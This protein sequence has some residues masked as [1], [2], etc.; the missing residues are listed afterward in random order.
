V[1]N[2]DVRSDTLSLNGSDEFLFNAQLNSDQEKPA[3]P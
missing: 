2:R 3:M 1:A